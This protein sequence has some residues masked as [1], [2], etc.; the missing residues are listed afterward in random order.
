MCSAPGHV[1][2]GPKADNDLLEGQISVTELLWPGI[3]YQIAS[4]RSH[5]IF[6]EAPVI[7]RPPCAAQWS[8]RNRI[9]FRQDGASQGLHPQRRPARLPCSLL[10]EIRP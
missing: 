7:F 3:V 4:C 2:F 6:D 10:S 9:A 1:R 8:S 5:V